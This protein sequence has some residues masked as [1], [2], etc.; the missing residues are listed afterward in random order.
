M[1]RVWQAT[2]TLSQSALSALE[3]LLLEHFE[4]VTTLLNDMG[5]WD[6]QV[7]LTEE[8][9]PQNFSEKLHALAGMVG[10]AVADPVIE[11]MPETDWLKHVYQQLAPMTLGRFF[12]H[13]EHYTDG[14]P[15]GKVPLL[16]EAATAFGTGGHPTT[17]TCM[18]ALDGLAQTGV[19]PKTVLDMG[20]GSG[21][22]AVAAAKIFD[23][24]VVAVDN[25]V[26]AERMTQH[27]AAQNNV[28]LHV[29]C[30]D[31]FNTPLV[32]EHGPYELIMANILAT[33]IIAM[34]PALT[35]QLA[36]QAY[37]IFSGFLTEH[38]DDVVKAYE[39]YGCVVQD[40]YERGD[41]A[42]L[43]MKKG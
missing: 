12:V 6:V 33:P 11:Q 4:T 5:T 27:A 42:A 23:A 35:A 9:E 24:T 13:G 34:A 39:T 41:W 38:A 14:T 21:I 15:E 40:Q 1:T 19:S 32:A 22:L 29:A 26:E 3:P 30:G 2:F 10:V 18:L 37:M 28:V 20:C 36:T 8:E 25:D 31:G 16:I 17:A 7:I 43:V